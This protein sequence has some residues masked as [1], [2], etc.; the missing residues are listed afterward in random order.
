MSK[1]VALLILDGFGIT[2][3][4]TGNAILN[5]PTPNLD[6]L[7][8]MFPKC[9]LKA[10]AEEVGL[11]WGEFG[12]SEVGHTTIGL[13]RI[14][15]QDLPQITAKLTNGEF[16]KKPQYKKIIDSATNGSNIHFLFVMSDGA[17]HGHINHLINLVKLIKSDRPKAKIILHMISDGRDTAEK[18]CK[19]YLD[20]INKQIGK[21]VTFGSLMGRYYAM[22]RDKNWDRIQL[23]YNAITGSA[24]RAETPDQVIEDSYAKGKTDEFIEPVSF[25]NNPFDFSKDLLI[26]T[27]YRSDR[28]VQITRAFV[29]PNLPE[30]KRRSITSN[31]FSM[32]TYDDN[33]GL[34]V[35]FSNLELNNPEVNPLRNP[36]SQI[37]SQNNFKQFHVAETEKFAHITYF[38]AGGEKKVFNGEV[39]KII[40]TKKVKSFDLY[41]QMRALEISSE[42]SAAANSGFDFIAANFA[43]GDMI[44]HT[45]NFEAAK[46]AVS[47][48][49]QVLGK[50]VGELLKKDYQVIITGDHGN[51][52]EM[53]DF[54]TGKPNKEHTLNPVPF[55]YCDLK[56][57]G[58]YITKEDLF[59]SE[60]VGILADIAPT[61][62]Q[63]LGIEKSPEMSGINLLGALR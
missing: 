39:D 33:L 49:D 13:G 29:D 52:D 59:N 21:L 34:N 63:S 55:I 27:N 43:N 47:I 57:K 19:L 23:A 54:A 62:S 51:C 42:I 32:T 8:P 24:E 15:L 50:L 25:G 18:S 2:P 3:E 45:G 35:L 37:V 30:L 44:G 17:V 46:Q 11:P 5:A 26:F 4:L 10:S 58:R 7:L 60:P 40:Q 38:F 36:L 31:F 16:R 61:I 6:A 20:H 41:P 28:A 12:S 56:Y 14:V 22:D 1:K 9:L 48:L 53:I